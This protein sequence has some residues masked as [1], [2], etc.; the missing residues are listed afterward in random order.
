MINSIP[1]ISHVPSRGKNQRL[2]WN[3][4]KLSIGNILYL[5]LSIRIRTQPLPIGASGIVNPKFR[6]AVLIYIEQEIPRFL[7]LLRQDTHYLPCSP[8][9]T[10]YTPDRPLANSASPPLP[11]C[12]SAAMTTPKRTRGP[13]T[14]NASSSLFL[15]FQSVF[16]TTIYAVLYRS[17]A[18]TPGKPSFP[19]AGRGKTK[20]PCRSQPYTTRSGRQ[21]CLCTL[22]PWSTPENDY[23]K[24]QSF[25]RAKQGKP[26]QRVWKNCIISSM[27][28][29]LGP[30][31]RWLWHLRRIS[32]VGA[33]K[34]AAYFVFHRYYSTDWQEIA[35]RKTAARRFWRDRGG[36]GKNPAPAPAK[37]EKTLQRQGFY[38]IFPCSGCKI[39]QYT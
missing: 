26:L 6:Y 33:L 12:P 25:N 34:S 8:G 35:S 14:I 29:G 31:C 32:G 13:T 7:F 38:L 20:M 28:C 9:Q 3:V 21:K 37:G 18:Q 36:A 1:K 16:G 5:D 15:L 39:S 30:L 4:G 23:D 24:R 2:P 10:G 19:R 11:T 17:P 22:C 27:R